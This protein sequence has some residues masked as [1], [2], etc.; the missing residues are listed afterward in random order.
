VLQ[1][2]FKLTD[3]VI[4]ENAA[5]LGNEFVGIISKNVADKYRTHHRHDADDEGHEYQNYLKMQ[6]SVQNLILAYQFVAEI[7]YPRPLL[8]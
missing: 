1:R 5:L 6:F 4:G 3:E 2:I 7:K 8:V